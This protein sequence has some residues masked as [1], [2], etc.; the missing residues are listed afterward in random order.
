MFLVQDDDNGFENVIYYLSR[1]LLDTKTQYA[2]V[3]K[4]SLVAVHIIQCFC[5]HILLCTMTVI[6]DC[7]LMMYILSRQFLGGKYSKWII[8]IQEFDLEFTT[9]SKKSLVFTKLIC[10]LPSATAPS[11]LEDRILDDTLFLISTLD[12]WY[13]D[14]I[15]YL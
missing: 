7:N 1:N 2:Y 13:A 10:L 3:E 5:H 9:K 4:L 12:P 6:S 8:I 15:I 11:R 14:I